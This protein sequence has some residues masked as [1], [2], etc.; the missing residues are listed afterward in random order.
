MKCDAPSDATGRFEDLV[1]SALEGKRLACL[2]FDALTAEIGALAPTLSGTQNVGTV[3][4]ASGVTLT[5][6]M[7]AAAARAVFRTPGSYRVQGYGVLDFFFARSEW[8]LNLSAFG[9]ASGNLTA[10]PL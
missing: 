4:S 9:R 3:K 6:R 1:A 7:D 10:T 2:N 5:L 8:Q